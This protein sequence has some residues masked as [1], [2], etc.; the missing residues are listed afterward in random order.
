MSDRGVDLGDAIR[1]MADRFRSEL[2]SKSQ[3][4]LQAEWAWRWEDRL[5]TEQNVYRFFSAL[6][7]HQ[8]RC[9]DWESLHNGITCV[10]ERVRDT[11]LMPRI[12][13]LLSELTAR[14]RP[15]AFQCAPPSST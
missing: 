11:Y 5:S 4:E 15:D 2:I 14:G 6:T 3:S 9:R 7:T 12:S 1:E 10:V 13:E 8:R